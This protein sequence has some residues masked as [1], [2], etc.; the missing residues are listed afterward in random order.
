MYLR[1]T[2]LIVAAFTCSALVAANPPP[3]HSYIPISKVRDLGGTAYHQAIKRGVNPHGP[4][5]DDFL[6]DNGWCIE[7]AEESAYALWAAAQSSSA[8]RF[9]R[10]T[11]VDIITWTAKNCQGSGKHYYNVNS[12]QDYYEYVF[13]FHLHA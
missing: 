12:F 2:S 7:F 13:L 8:M 9:K 11:G 4:P 1:T 6:S 5:P 3:I 10:G